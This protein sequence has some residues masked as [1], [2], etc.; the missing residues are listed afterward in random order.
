MTTA[1]FFTV[2]KPG[3]EYGLLPVVQAAATTMPPAKRVTLYCRRDQEAQEKGQRVILERG[4]RVTAGQRLTLYDERDACVVSPVAGSIAEVSSYIDDSGRDHVSVVIDAVDTGEIDESFSS[5]SQDPTLESVGD[6]L[7]SLPGRPPIEALRDPEMSIDTL[8][9]CGIDGDLFVDT[10]Q[11][12]VRSNIDAV[13]GGIRILKTLSGIENIVM[14]VPKEITQGLGSIGARVKAV[15][16]AYPA[17]LPHMIMQDVLGKVVPAG[18]R[19]EDLGVVF[20]TAEA[21]ASIGTAFEEGRLP[22]SKILTLMKKDGSR[23]LVSAGL[24]TPIRDIF[25]ACD[26]TLGEGDRIILGGPMTGATIY[27]EDHPVEP[28]TDAIVVQDREDLALVSDYPCVN[29][30]ECVR[31][32]PARIQVN[33]LIRFLEAGQFEEAAEKQDL[34]SCIEC[35]LC[36]FACVSRMPVFQ[37]IR[38]AKSELARNSIVAETDDAEPE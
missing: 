27:S 37:Y 3:M 36:S 29:C 18:K 24:G 15:D 1:S 20:F 19:C 4:E 22:F 38:L 5:L 16:P 25:A 26:V 34:Y 28:D 12:V 8:V 33:M 7:A 21:V 14:V 9:V 17:A 13:K 2:K 31:I 23:L 6:Y 11:S 10:N 30:G 32:C 35:G